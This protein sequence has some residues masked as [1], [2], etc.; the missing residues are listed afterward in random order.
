MFEQPTYHH[1]TGDDTATYK[2]RHR[3]QKMCNSSFVTLPRRVERAI[4]TGNMRLPT[5][6]SLKRG[7]SL[8]AEMNKATL[9]I[10]QRLRRIMQLRSE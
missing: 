2:L 9:W 4:R 1:Q 3:Q 8:A 5:T 10:M 7:K 6:A